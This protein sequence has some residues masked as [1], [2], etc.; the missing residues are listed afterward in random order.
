MTDVSHEG[1]YRKPETEF[2]H[3]VDQIAAGVQCVRNGTMNGF[4]IRIEEDKGI[5]VEPE[6][7]EHE[8]GRIMC[9]AQD[10]G[11]TV[12]YQTGPDEEH[13]R[14]R[15]PVVYSDFQDEM[16]A[17]RLGSLDLEKG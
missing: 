3:W 8:I 9:L 6:N 7:V 11:I 1:G 15:S 13:V 4:F 5:Y 14:Q 17:F 12:G 10:L 16:D 2:E